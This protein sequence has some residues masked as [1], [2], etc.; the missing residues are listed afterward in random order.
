MQISFPQFRF[1]PKICFCSELFF[2]FL[3]QHSVTIQ[4]SPLGSTGAA[5]RISWPLEMQ[6]GG[7]SNLRR[8]L[9]STFDGQTG[10]GSPLFGLDTPS[11]ERHSTSLH[12]AT[13]VASGYRT[14]W[15]LVLPRRR[16]SWSN[17]SGRRFWAKSRYVSYFFFKIRR[18]Q[19][20][21]ANKILPSFAQFPRNSG[22]PFDVA[23]RFCSRFCLSRMENSRRVELLTRIFGFVAIAR[24]F[25]S[26]RELRLARL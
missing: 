24:R 11:L 21:W 23:K 5:N 22:F 3:A 1:Y 9:T 12:S 14:R 19:S 10:R 25:T 4:N 6:S 13:T 26:K 8:D 15:P 20:S 7:S 2:L 18:R 16:S 17:S